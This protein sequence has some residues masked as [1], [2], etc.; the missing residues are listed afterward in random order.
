MARGD[1]KQWRTQHHPRA[2]LRTPAAQATPLP[3]PH[4]T[5]T[6]TYT[7]ARAPPTAARQPHGTHLPDIA[8]S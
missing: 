4:C 2:A 8:N 1:A 3:I 5:H 6:H 7:H